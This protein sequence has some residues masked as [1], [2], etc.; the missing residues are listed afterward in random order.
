MTTMPQPA[1]HETG[2]PRPDQPRAVAPAAREAALPAPRP[3]RRAER[4]RDGSWV[5]GVA[6]GVAANL[7]WSTTAVRLGFVAL[8]FANFLG[9]FVYGLLWVLM[10]RQT[11]A[12]RA[13]GL[14]AASHLDMRTTKPTADRRRDA[15]A[16]TVMAIL[17]I[18]VVWLGQT[19]GM[20]LPINWFWPLAFAVVG[21]AL[22]WR[23]ADADPSPDKGTN[24]WLR[25]F[26][27]SHGWT[28]ITRMVVGVGMVSLAVSA[29]VASSVG[30]EQL[31]SLMLLTG[32]VLAGIALIAAPWVHRWRAEMTQTREAR[33]LADARADMAAHLHDSVLQTLA[34]I[35]RQSEDPKAV[36]SL[37]RRQERELRGWLYG[38]DEHPSETQLAQALRR[39]GQEIEDERGVAVE[40]ICVGDAELTSNLVALV[41]A[42]RE[43]M[44]N[45]AKHSGADNIDV[46]AEVEDGHVEVF[47]RDRGKGF[48]MADI[49]DDR[50]G[51]RNSIIA[52][53]E[54]HGGTAR[55]RS[56]PGEGAD[57]KLE[58]DID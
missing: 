47:I 28:G 6:A 2:Q 45:A 26:V 17:G 22:I 4:Q 11:S 3:V 32:V 33:I 1:P 15:G 7:N 40:V 52:R 12:A 51:V 39:A 57:I 44:M 54:R 56:A 38:E 30:L 43:A 27:S 46:F 20:G 36:A 18:G 49:A 35:Q 9:V 42:A 50:Q 8:T 53:M 37:A 34:L 55:I 41:S 16:V 23:Q 13:P 24:K 25:P 48:D 19:M 58:M 31:P 10:P 21:L 29:V 14:D 5:A